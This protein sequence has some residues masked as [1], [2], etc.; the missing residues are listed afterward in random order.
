MDVIVNVRF[1]NEH[2]NIPGMNVQYCKNL[3][4]NKCVCF[5]IS[6]SDSDLSVF[7]SFLM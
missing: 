1:L 3:C 7:H 6:N 4:L 2:S 5:L